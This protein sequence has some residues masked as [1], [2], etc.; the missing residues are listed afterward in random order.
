MSMIVIKNK[1]GG[2]GT[3]ISQLIDWNSWLFGMNIFHYNYTSDTVNFLNWFNSYWFKKVWNNIYWLSCW[4]RGTSGTSPVSIRYLKLNWNPDWTYTIDPS[5]WFKSY[6]LSTYGGK[7]Y[8]IWYI[9]K[10]TWEIKF[11]Y[12]W[13]RNS[14]WSSYWYTTITIS[15]TWVLSWGI[16]NNK[17]RSWDYAPSVDEV[18][19]SNDVVE[20]W[21]YMYSL[22]KHHT[23]NYLMFWLI[24]TI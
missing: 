11:W 4:Y 9:N 3:P 12:W 1:K 2:G 6:N 23:N 15:P 5:S 22:Q 21:W 10:N 7:Q 19:F 8:T 16:N 17:Q 13:Q 14:A 20:I 18:F 24:P